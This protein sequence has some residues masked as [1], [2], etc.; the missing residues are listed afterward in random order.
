MVPPELSPD[1][2]TEGN[3]HGPP[4]LPDEVRF[5]GDSAPLVI[6]HNDGI[7]LTAILFRDA[8]P[9]WP[10]VRDLALPALTE[11][12][13]DLWLGHPGLNP[14]EVSRVDRRSRQ[15]HEQ[16]R[17]GENRESGGDEEYDLNV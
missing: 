12:R 10:M 2:I 8:C 4:I 17:Q 5:G 13:L 6:P 3:V 7:P 9:T 16:A 14:R 1:F 15:P 11:D